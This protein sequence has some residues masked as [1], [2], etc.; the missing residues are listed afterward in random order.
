[1]ELQ[2]EVEAYTRLFGLVGGP[3]PCRRHLK[4]AVSGGESRQGYKQARNQAVCKSSSNRVPQCAGGEQM[5]SI[6]NEEI[7]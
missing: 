7:E 1:M 3:W 6:H 2:E 5:V 4:L